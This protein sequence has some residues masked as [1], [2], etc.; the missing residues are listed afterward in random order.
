MAGRNTHRFGGMAARVVWLGGDQWQTE[1]ELYE[2]LQGLREV[3]WNA[4]MTRG[5]ALEP[6]A[7]RLY[8]EQTGIVTRPALIVHPEHPWAVASVDGI[9][10]EGDR[11]LEVKCPSAEVHASIVPGAVPEDYLVQIRWYLYL[12][13]AAICDLVSYHPD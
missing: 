1:L 6:E 9:S 13:G 3:E 2:Y 12:T 4:G 7:R 10:F 8:E 5:V 11:L